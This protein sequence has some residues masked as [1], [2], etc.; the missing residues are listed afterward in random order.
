VNRHLRSSIVSVMAVAM[1]V[2]G[3]AMALPAWAV[4]T[5]NAA[6]WS[7]DEPAG[8]SVMT[9]NSGQGLHGRVGADV[10]TGTLFGGATGYR[11]PDISPTAPPA[12]PEH[13]VTVPHTTRLN[14]ESADYSVTIRY[15]TT[16]SFGNI[17]QK[18]QNATAGGYWK[19]EQPNGKVACLFKGSG[20]GQRTAWSLTALNDGQWHTVKCERTATAV[21]MYVDGVRHSRNPGWTGPIANTWEMSIGGKSRCDQIRTTCDYFVGDIDHVRVEKGSAG[22]ANQPPVP[23]LATEC[24]GMVCSLSA[25]GS[26]DADGA[27]QSYAWNFGDGSSV[28]TGSVRSTTHTY[29]AAGTY[30]V[31]LTVTDDRGVSSSTTSE[32]TVAPAA[33]RI[34]FVGQ[35]TSSGNVRTHAVTVPASVQPGDGLVLFFSENTHATIAEPTGVT[36]WVPLQQLDGGYATSRVWRKVA[37]PGDAGSTLRVTLSAQSKGVLT[38]AAYRGTSTSDPVAA[39]AAAADTTRTASRVTPTVTVPVSGAWALS[40]WMHGDGTS[41]AL[42]P[43]SGVTVRAGA[44]QTGG[45][46]VTTLLADSAAGLPTGAYGGLTATGAATSTTTTTWTVVLHPEG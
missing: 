19:F 15:R 6:F 46:R 45:G 25:A 10:Q 1:A 5:T 35:A 13:L 12:R 29:A 38:V 34:S 36:G 27:I 9:D 18:G 16:K 24:S 37:G 26:T 7:M 33:E 11:F 4:A 2:A 31:T 20:G 43:P 23:S 8:S 17:A 40:Y 3:I 22:P 32:V 30:P 14:P 28:D 39:Y 41:T 44:S 21:S 42:T